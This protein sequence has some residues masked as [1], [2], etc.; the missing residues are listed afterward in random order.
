M[1][2]SPGV[3]QSLVIRRVTASGAYL[4]APEGTDVILLPG[5]EIPPGAKPGDRLDAFVTFDSEDRP[6][7]TLLR[8]A[9]EMGRL[10]RL[11][12]VSVVWEGAFLAWGLPKDLLLPRNQW[13]GTLR[14]GDRP[15][16]ALTRDRAGRLA[17]TMRIEPHLSC[18][19]PYAVDDEVAG[20]VYHVDRRMGA[21]VAVDDR[22]HGMIPRDEMLPVPSRG[23]TVRARVTRVREDGKL[24]LSPRA[25][26]YRQMDGDAAAIL[27]LLERA[28]GRIALH[29]GS[30]PEEIRAALGMGKAAFKRAA[31]RLFKNRKIE[32]IPG[33]M[34]LA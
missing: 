11:P 28:G 2:F 18:D 21:F 19:A 3:R 12:V 17:A 6:V 23:D 27:A 31:G 15:L 4:G 26:A 1:N 16:V 32:F 29:D 30:S 5:A 14:P 9:I 25:K 34:R 24:D 33:G 10:A 7:A 22:Y 8:P 13:R 20:T